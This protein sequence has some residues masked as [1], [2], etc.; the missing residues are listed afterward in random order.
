M[1]LSVPL[2]RDSIIIGIME[3]DLLTLSLLAVT[4]V[5]CFANSLDP[6]CTGFKPFDTLTLFDRMSV[7]YWTQTV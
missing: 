5:I 4:F 2:M 6:V 7:L 3:L 1:Y